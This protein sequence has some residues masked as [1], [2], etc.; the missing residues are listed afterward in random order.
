MQVL[1]IKFIKFTTVLIQIMAFYDR[2]QQNLMQ[3]LPSKFIQFT[4]DLTQIIPPNSR[5]HQNTFRSTQDTYGICCDYLHYAGRIN[6]LLQITAVEARPTS[7][8]KVHMF[9]HTGRVKHPE[10][11]E[12]SR[13]FRFSADTTSKS[14]FTLVYVQKE[15]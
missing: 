9:E 13:S 10:Y 14:H 7:L 5:I 8:Q 15:R 4:N 11:L 1:S 6:V 3:V 12:C 2:R